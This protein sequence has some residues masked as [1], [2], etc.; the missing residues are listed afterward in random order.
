MKIW[1]LDKLK[2]LPSLKLAVVGHVEFVRFLSVDQL[3]KAGS[4]SHSRSY[5]EEPAGGGAIAAVQMQNLTQAQV[6]FFTSLGKDS[7]GER[8]YERLKEFGLTLRVAWR[9]KATRQGISFVDSSGERGITVIGERLQ[10]N[11]RDDL[12]WD[13]LSGFDGIFFTAGDA[14]AMKLSRKAKFLSATPRVGID[15]INKSAV[16]LDVLIGSGLDI[17]E[18]YNID[19][20]KIR[21]KMRI[22]TEG[23]KGGEVWPGGRYKAVNL[24]SKVIDTYGCG[25]RFAAGVTTGMAAGWNVKKALSLGAHCGANCT[26]YFGPYI[27][28]I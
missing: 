23:S 14:N 20:I 2:N 10:P 28:E 19:E 24:K 9:E 26:S 15:E 6:H 22:S 21:P 8:C 25:D 16:Q 12:P 11:S 13:E 4:I 5:I 27:N 3:P 17:G 7:I 1:E 18:K